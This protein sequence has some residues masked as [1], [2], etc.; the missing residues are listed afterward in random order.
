[1]FTKNSFDRRKNSSADN[2]FNNL[3]HIFTLATQLKTKEI[4]VLLPTRIVFKNMVMGN[5]ALC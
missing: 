1:M 5:N 2:V 4:P 3:K